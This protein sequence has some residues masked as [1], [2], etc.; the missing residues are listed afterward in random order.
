MKYFLGIDTSNYRTSA[1]VCDE[2]GNP[3][4][5]VRRLLP[6]AEGQLGL[7]QS[8]A[9]FEHVKALPEIM[10]E[11]G[12]VCPTAVGYSLRP[13]DVEGSYMPCFLAGASVARS[14]ASAAGVQSY[15]F[16]HQAGHV[17]AAAY[18]C[19][20]SVVPSFREL[21]ETED[22]RFAAFHVSGGTT[23]VLL[24]E[25]GVIKQIGGTL[26]LCAGQLIDRVGVMLGLGF[27]CGSMLE[28][29]AEGVPASKGIK[30][31]VKDLYCNFAGLENTAS[32]MF[33]SGVP[34]EEIAAFTLDAVGKTVDRLSENLL[35]LYPGIPILYAGGVM[36][37]RRIANK[38]SEKYACGFAGPEYS[39][40]NAMG[41]ALLCRSRYMKGQ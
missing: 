1:A 30:I 22:G 39:G 34:K 3:V 23:E 2:N 32:K 21:T 40:D 38:L 20:G 19:D 24:Y 17:K 35:S 5:N 13:R 18:F 10:E 8:Q 11:L 37:C 7:R 6:V 9:L 36:S 28:K 41:T 16:S 26:D 4:R 29:M 14:I 12:E 31:S 25:G 27:P 15:P 33:G